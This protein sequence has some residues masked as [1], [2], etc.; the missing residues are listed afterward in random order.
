MG[1]SDHMLSYFEKDA[2]R[3]GDRLNKRV[4]SNSAFNVRVIDGLIFGS[5]YEIF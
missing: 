1:K 3:Y 2:M 5:V 4:H